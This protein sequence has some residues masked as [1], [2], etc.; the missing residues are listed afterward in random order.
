MITNTEALE[1]HYIHV[2]ASKMIKVKKIIGVY[3][4]L[5]TDDKYEVVTRKELIFD[6]YNKVRDLP[7]EEGQ[8]KH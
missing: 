2:R 6:N 3:A 5:E 7:K 1:G 4:I 8:C